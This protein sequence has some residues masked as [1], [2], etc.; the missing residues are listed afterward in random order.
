MVHVGS[1]SRPPTRSVRIVK[2][3][4]ATYAYVGGSTLPA[5]I[6]DDETVLADHLDFM[7]E[8]INSADVR[9]A[10][11]MSLLRVRARNVR[12]TYENLCRCSVDGPKKPFL[13]DSKEADGDTE[14]KI[15]SLRI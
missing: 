5:P 11:T 8:E 1:S 15:S 7:K 6:A 2:N 13:C 12:A 10:P 9:S 4:R 3:R 14:T